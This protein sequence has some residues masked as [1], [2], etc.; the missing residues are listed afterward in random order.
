MADEWGKGE[1]KDG[2]SL[3]DRGWVTGWTLRQQN[4]GVE[5]WRSGAGLA[6]SVCG[7]VF[8]FGWEREKGEGG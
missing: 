3:R 2:R 6:M 5:A 8:C 4:A 7:G 1:L